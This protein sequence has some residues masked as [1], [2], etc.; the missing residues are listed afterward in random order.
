MSKS[1][2]KA[3]SDQRAFTMVYNDF[4][5]SNLLEPSEKLLYIY[6]KMHAGSGTGQS[7]PSLATLARETGMSKR[8]VQRWLSEMEDKGVIAIE[9]RQSSRGNQSNLYTIRDQAKLWNAKDKS[10]MQSIASG[11]KDEELIEYLKGKGYEITKKELP[12]GTDQSSDESTSS[13]LGVV[14]TIDNSTVT[15]V[16]SQ[17][18]YSMDD[19]KA[20]FDYALLAS[21]KR[22]NIDDVDAVMQILYDVLN[23]SKSTIRV[24]KQ[25]K[26]A[27]VV[28]GKMMKLT[29]EEIHYAIQ[30]YNSVTEKISNPTAYMLTLLYNAKEQMTLDVTNQVNH[31]LYGTDDAE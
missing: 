19:V 2:I 14:T 23:T 29:S 27:M 16:E 31:D 30:K 10:E 1:R 3:A 7:F 13:K 22:L 20:L 6:L 25:N 12:S 11:Q 5:H 17:E 9:H 18:R 21:D 24:A 8:T 28:V 4:L 15:Y 26:P